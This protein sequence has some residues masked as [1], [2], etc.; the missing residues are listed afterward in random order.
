MKKCYSFPFDIKSVRIGNSVTSIGGS[1]FYYCSKL[2]SITIPDSVTSIG[3]DAFCGCSSLTSMTIPDSV[4][5][6]GSGAFEDC[7][8]LTNVT[9]GNSVTS[10]GSYA[11]RSCNSL[12]SVT[13]PDSVTSIGGGAFCDCS[14]LEG[15]DVNVSNQKYTSFD[16]IL[17][18]K[19]KTK[20]ICYP[21]AKED[22]YVMHDSVIC[23]E[24]YAFSNSRVKSVETSKRLTTIGDQEFYNCKNLVSVI[25]SKRVTNVGGFAFGK[26]SN[27]SS[28]AVL[29]RDI[30]ISGDA[31]KN[32]PKLIFSGYSE[33]TTEKYAK[34][35]HIPFEEIEKRE[36]IVSG[37]CGD[38]LSWILYEDGEL[39]IDG[40]G[41]MIE[42]KDIDAPWYGYRSAIKTIVIEVDAT[43]IGENAFKYC[44]NLT[45]IIIPDSVKCIGSGA[46]YG[47]RNLKAIY[48]TDIEAWQNIQF[49]DDPC[50]NG[51]KLFVLGT[52][53][54]ELIIS[55]S[56]TDIGE[57]V[58]SGYIGLTSVTIPQSVTS[59]GDYAFSDCVNLPKIK[60]PTS[61]TSIGS[62]A[63][64]GCRRLK[65][66]LI[67]DSVTAIGEGAL[68]N[69][70]N[71]VVYGYA[72][73][74]AETYAIENDIKFVN[75]GNANND[76][77]I[78]TVDY[79]DLARYLSSP[80]DYECKL[81]LL[82]AD[83][84]GDGEV[85]ALDSVIFARHIAGWLG[86]ERLP[87]C[88]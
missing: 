53:L 45:S 18:D 81:D 70:P 4:I 57:Y 55:E 43:S 10:I 75:P 88:G 2:T 60:I 67:P 26:C 62:R 66:I 7:S 61:V 31:F 9:I 11:F 34:E 1:A 19:A 35:Y 85:N 54:N 27:L 13:I 50:R 47:C 72:G 87:Y 16:G 24:N 69:C 23:I 73:S 74:A 64:S 56:I 77:N 30:I 15:I 82:Y 40:T 5:S 20:L 22:E 71:L 42:W 58:F 52:E 79:L 84:N 44:R 36:T 48:I 49:A 25:I 3:D 80:G 28:V 37:K 6:I 63:F 65:T 78:D 76:E 38:N 12:T 21:A 86:Y 51:A 39:N 41:A 33:S 17:F 32:C 14:S 68:S 59:I 83:M 29:S 46:F 8:N